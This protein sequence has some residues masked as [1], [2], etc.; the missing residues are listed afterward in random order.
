MDTVAAR[1]FD[2]KFSQPRKHQ[3]L[4]DTRRRRSLFIF[5]FDRPW[6]VFRKCFDSTPHPI[7]ELSHAFVSHPNRSPY[8]QTSQWI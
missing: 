2:S 7:V 3:A 6:S 1:G 4:G 8:L 5:L